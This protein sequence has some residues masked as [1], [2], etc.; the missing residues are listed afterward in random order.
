MKSYPPVAIFYAVILAGN[1]QAGEAD[2]ISARA[3]CDESNT[4]SF[5]VTVKHDDQGWD[6]YANQWQ[7]LS[8]GGEVLGTRGLHHPH[9]HEQPFTRSLSGI[10]IPTGIKQVRI[11]ARD[12]V[13]DYGGKE[14][15]IDIK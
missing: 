13:H 2:V 1:T 10:K 7:V 8:M 3:S 6:H 5:S 4:C 14:F 9:E 12:S 15:T 11:R